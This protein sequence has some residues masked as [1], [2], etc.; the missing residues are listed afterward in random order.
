MIYNLNVT[1]IIIAHILLAA[2]YDIQRRNFQIDILSFSIKTFILDYL[3][4]INT[5]ANDVIILNRI[6]LDCFDNVS[7]SSL[8][9]VCI[10]LLKQRVIIQL[11]KNFNY[12]I[13]G[14]FN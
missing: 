4:C 1:S 12:L 6:M 14:Y 10:F 3:I 13:N 9:A 2:Q 5:F 8:Q 7:T 11:I